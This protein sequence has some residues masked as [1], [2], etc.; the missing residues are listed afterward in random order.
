M[1]LI[2][3]SA[4]RSTQDEFMKSSL[5]GRSLTI[6]GQLT[7]VSLR[8]FFNNTQPLGFCYNI[9]IDEAES[10]DILVFVHDDVHI[11]D[12]MMGWRVQEALRHFD[13]VGVAGNRRC[14]S[15]QLTWYLQPSDH[16][17]GRYENSDW[18]L[19][20]LS[21]AIGHGRPGQNRLSNYGSTPQLV[22]LIDGVF[23][24]ARARTLLESGVRFDPQLGFHLYDLDFCRSADRA[25]LKIGTWPIALTH[26]SSG[27]GIHSE[28]WAE[29]SRIYRSKWYL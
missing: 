3:V 18:D 20:Y 21:G 8:G 2:V 11:D 15:G 19:A 14:Q 16:T 4:T 29:S 24:A 27:D 12:W 9:A 6:I 22:S 17:D 28:A 25:G 10:D 5:L 1:S 13:V 23:M 26:A 7:T